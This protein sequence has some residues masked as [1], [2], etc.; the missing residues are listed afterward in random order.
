M[1]RSL[2]PTIVRCFDWITPE[3]AVGGCFSADDTDDLAST[4]GVG[5]V[6]DLRDEACDDE[7]HLAR[8]GIAFLHLPTPDNRGVSLAHLHAGVSFVCGQL[9][10][11]RRV[12]IHCQ[13]GIGRA[14]LLALCVLVERGHAPLAALAL[15]KDRRAVTSPSPEQYEAWAAWLRE[16]GREPPRF[17]DF[18]AIAYRH[19]RSA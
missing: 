4:H 10:K 7:S 15:A 16:H 17:D 6:V 18:A 13:H 8:C 12:L 19:L 11:R 1:T 9:A 2:L 14:A 3:L 5:A